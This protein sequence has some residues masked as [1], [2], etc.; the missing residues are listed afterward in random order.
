[1]VESFFIMCYRLVCSFVASLLIC[2]LQRFAEGFGQGLENG[3]GQVFCGLRYLPTILVCWLSDAFG[4][5]F[6]YLWQTK[7]HTLIQCWT[8]VFKAPLRYALVVCLHFIPPNHECFVNFYF[9]SE[10][11]WRSYDISVSRQTV[12][13][14]RYMFM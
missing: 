7:G 5:R 3:F 6:S 1:M 11:C 10:K 2:V 12:I 8:Y 4:T 14:E 13:S 9:K